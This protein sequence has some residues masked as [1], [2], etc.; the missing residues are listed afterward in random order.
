M[1][2]LDTLKFDVEE[3]YRLPRY[4]TKGYQRLEIV[5]HKWSRFNSDDCVENKCSDHDSV[6]TAP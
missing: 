1:W 2:P 6:A 3:L 5:L 4:S